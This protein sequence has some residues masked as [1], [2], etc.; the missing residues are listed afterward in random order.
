MERAS[1]VLVVGLLL[2]LSLFLPATGDCAQ[3][4]S[5]TYTFTF[6]WVPWSPLYRCGQVFRPGGEFQRMLYEKSAGRIQ[7]NIVE[8]MFPAK[9]VMPAVIEGR[10]DLG[11]ISLPLYSGTYPYFLWGDVPGVLSVEPEQSRAEQLAV[12]QDPRLLKIWNQKHR[13]LGLTHLLTA[14]GGAGNLLA[15]K[16]P[17]A[18]LDDIKGMKIRVAGNIATLGTK[19]FGGIPTPISWEDMETALVTGTVDAT[20]TGALFA[21]SV[22]L[23]RLTPNMV[24]TPLAPTW[25]DS[26]AMNTK[27]FETLPPDLQQVVRDVSQRLEPMIAL[28]NT[29]ELIMAIQSLKNSNAKII[30]FDKADQAR[31]LELVKPIESEWLKLSGPSGSEILSIAKDVIAKYRSFNPTPKK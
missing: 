18:K 23:A 28:A 10:A 26:V 6:A 17:L 12:F 29:A 22:G 31:A 8:K 14:A 19:A 1:K 3:A 5:D 15:S 27:K 16:K 13:E 11:F 21:N 20:L 4:K 24:F 9:E 25:L 7:L 2:V 30:N